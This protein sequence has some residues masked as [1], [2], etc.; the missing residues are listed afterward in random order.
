M[1]TS[2]AVA[3]AAAGLAG[4]GGSGGSAGSAGSNGSAGSSGSAG[5]GGSNASSG[6]TG[7]TAG[8]SYGAASSTSTSASPTAVASASGGATTLT[9]KRISGLGTVLAAGSK[10]LT[11]YAFAAD[12][13]GKSRCNGSCATI[14]PPLEA[15]GALKGVGGVSRTALGTI[16]RSNGSK[17]VTY[18][19]HPVYFYASDSSSGNAF[20]EGIESF[21]ARWYA[22]SPTGAE[23][24]KG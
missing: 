6:K 15:K 17:Q 21:G 20:G 8:Y 14:W 7:E 12:S 19:G 10:H 24:K 4:C 5:S 22:L 16:T 13:P 1:A 18:H 2:L 3:L 23:V 11:L 9:T